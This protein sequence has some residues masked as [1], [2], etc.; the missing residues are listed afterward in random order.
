MQAEAQAKAEA[1]ATKAAN[2]APSSRRDYQ[3]VRKHTAKKWKIFKHTI[4]LL[5]AII[6]IS[7]TAAKP[8]QPQLNNQKATAKRQ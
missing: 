1:K 5:L 2:K 8:I 7:T 6:Q 3:K 4:S